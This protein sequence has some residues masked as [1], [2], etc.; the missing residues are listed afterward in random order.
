MLE[1]AHTGQCIASPGQHARYLSDHGIGS[2]NNQDEAYDHC[3]TDDTDR[4]S[5]DRE[6]DNH[7]YGYCDG[8][9]VCSHPDAVEQRH[10]SPD[11]Q[12][13]EQ[14]CLS[15]LPEEQEQHS[16]LDPLAAKRICD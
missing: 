10:I 12:W 8:T 13:L 2:R 11:S 7:D 4:N 6:A 1:M 5:Q 3:T 15:N 14:E 9:S 16:H